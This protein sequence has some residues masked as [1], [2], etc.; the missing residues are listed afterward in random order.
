VTAKERSV[1]AA[2]AI[3]FDDR[4]LRRALVLHHP[5]DLERARFALDVAERRRRR[6]QAAAASD[7]ASEAGSSPSG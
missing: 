7:A 5:L 6:D 3:E 1:A 2:L 4:P